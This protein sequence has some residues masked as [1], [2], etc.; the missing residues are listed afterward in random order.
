MTLHESLGEQTPA[1]YQWTAPKPVP[2]EKVNLTEIA[3]DAVIEANGDTAAS[4]TLFLSRLRKEHK[5]V[6]SQKSD[7]AMQGWAQDM[8]RHARTSLR[9]RLA[10]APSGSMTQ[11]HQSLDAESLTSAAIAWLDWPVLPG[12]ML[13]DATKADLDKA[14]GFYLSHATIYTKRGNWLHSIADALPDDATKVSA[15]LSE[16]AI[17]QLASTHG[18]AAS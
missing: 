9:N 15:A 18:V 2:A 6:Y 7:E 11:S 12:V 1:A 13:R 16:D 5:A 8:I 4:A 17:A 14:S 10:T 3:T